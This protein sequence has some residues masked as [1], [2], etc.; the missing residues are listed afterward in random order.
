[1]TLPAVADGQ[2]CAD[3]E[4]DHEQ[5]DLIER[6]VRLR[7]DATI[8]LKS[9]TQP[10]TCLDGR[11]IPPRI[12]DALARDDRQDIGQRTDGRSLAFEPRGPQKTRQT[13]GRWSAMA[14]RAGKARTI[15][16]AKISDPLIGQSCPRTDGL[17]ADFVPDQALREL[18]TPQVTG[19]AIF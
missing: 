12:G 9:V 1:M 8:Q 7:H 18:D 17:R 5:N 16:T 2:V 11:K 13:L 6:H 15:G 3:G 10:L 14:L 19:I 4:C